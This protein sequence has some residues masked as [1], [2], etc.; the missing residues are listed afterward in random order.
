VKLA[1]T[2]KGF[3]A[4]LEGEYDGVAEQE[5]YMKGNIDEIKK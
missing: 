2:I 4:I 5:F 1:D 3:K